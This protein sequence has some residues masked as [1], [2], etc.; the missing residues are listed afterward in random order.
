V[1][2]GISTGTR[3]V[4][5]RTAELDFAIESLDPRSA[6][7]GGGNVGVCVQDLMPGTAAARPTADPRRF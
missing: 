6:R 7:A 1:I 3:T 5:Q 4:A 2:S